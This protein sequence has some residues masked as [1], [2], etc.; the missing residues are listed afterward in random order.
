M[1]GEAG[2]GRGQ[3]PSR[4]QGAGPGPTGPPRGPDIVQGVPVFVSPLELPRYPDGAQLSGALPHGT[5]PDYPIKHPPGA[6]SNNGDH[7]A[8][9]PPQGGPVLP[10]P[11]QEERQPPCQPCRNAWPSTR[12][13]GVPR[14]AAVLCRLPDY[15][16][17]APG[18]H[19]RRNGVV[20][21]Q[22]CPRLTRIASGLT[23][24]F[25]L[26][27]SLGMESNTPINE[28]ILKRRPAQ[29]G[30]CITP[31]RSTFICSRIGRI[32]DPHA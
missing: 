22:A 29:I 17:R 21:C 16:V 8:Q 5:P 18:G 1:S 14:A 32:A 26:S 25:C 27:P 31:C 6:V 15:A 30:L 24:R 11:P 2:V 9:Q 19:V 7:Q 13:Q 23:S 20:I 10:P 4:Q 12:R 28:Q 3:E